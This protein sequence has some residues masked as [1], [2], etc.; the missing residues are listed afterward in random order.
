MWSLCGLPGSRRNC[1]ALR[2]R[3]L[4]HRRA[5][6]PSPARCAARALEARCRDTDSY[7]LDTDTPVAAGPAVIAFGEQHV[8]LDGARE[9]AAYVCR[10]CGGGTS[11]TPTDAPARTVR[12]WSRRAVGDEVRPNRSPTVSVARNCRYPC[13]RCRATP[14]RTAPIHGARER[15]GTS[16]LPSVLWSFG[17]CAPHRTTTRTTVATA[18]C[19]DHHRTPIRAHI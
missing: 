19:H 11:N 6:A 5:R 15:A 1:R 2:G 14:P 12:G 9:G 4:V 3:G 18:Q 10:L 8:M 13:T 16:P 17:D 7:G